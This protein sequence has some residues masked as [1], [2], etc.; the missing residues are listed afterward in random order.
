MRGTN[1]PGVDE[2]GHVGQLDASALLVA[3]PHGSPSLRNPLSRFVKDHDLPFAVLRLK[4][5]AGGEAR[6]ALEHAAHLA[7]DQ[8]QARGARLD[9][10]H[11]PV[12]GQVVVDHGGARADGPQAQPDP[13][14]AGLVHEVEGHDLALLDGIPL[15]Q[16]GGI[17]TDYV[18][19]L[20]VGPVAA[21]VDEE[22]PVG[23][24]GLGREGN[25]FEEVEGGEL[26]ASLVHALVDLGGD[27]G[28][29]HG[30]VVAN[31][32]F[33]V[34]V[35]H[36]GEGGGGGREEGRGGGGHCGVF[37]WFGGEGVGVG[38]GVGGLAGGR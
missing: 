2:H 22:W 35:G 24:G 15:L 8:H 38:V 36:Q 33:R 18:V 4:L 7:V 28:A 12:A 16:P 1:E 5:L 3:G 20:L 19:A 23:D 9:A 14:H 11:E 13:Q 37:V 21:L 29:D 26:V 6:F 25:V 17:A 30:D 31:H 10:V 32:V 27:E 34:E